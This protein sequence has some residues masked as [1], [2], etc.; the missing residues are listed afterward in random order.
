MKAVRALRVVEWAPNNGYP[1]ESVAQSKGWPV[2]ELG[3]VTAAVDTSRG[4]VY[5]TSLVHDAVAVLAWAAK[6]F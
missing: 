2:V 1:L 6:Q 3:G 5:V 4:T